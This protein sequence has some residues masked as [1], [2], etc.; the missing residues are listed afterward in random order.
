MTT[1]TEASSDEAVLR[2]RVR[3]LGGA[4]SILAE[5]VR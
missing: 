5:S 4:S 2:L 1:S 3:V